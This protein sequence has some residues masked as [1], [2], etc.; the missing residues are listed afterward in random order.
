MSAPILLKF[1]G[2][3]L[4]GPE[5]IVRAVHA[6]Y[7]EVRR[8]RRVIAVTSAFH[9]RT[10]ELERSLAS[11][12]HRAD[13]R[14]IAQVR[15]ALLATGEV[16]TANLLAAALD[17]SG[18]PSQAVDVRRFGPF[19]APGTETPVRF[20]AAGL[21]ALF[22]GGDGAP[23]PAVV[24]LPGFAAVE[25]TPRK[26]PA[27]LGRGGSDM[28]A[29]FVGHACGAEVTLVK[30]VEG[31]YTSDPTRPGPDGASPRRLATVT[32]GDAAGL[33][34]NILQPQAVALAEALDFPFDVVGPGALAGGRGTRVGAD[35]TLAR[36]RP[37]PPP[38]VRVALLGLGNVGS[39][40]FAE[41]SSAPDRF[42][43]TSVLV[44][45]IDGRPR[46]A[47]AAAVLTESFDDVL[48]SSPD[49][50]IET[51][52]GAE[53]ATTW[54]IRALR[55]GVHVV[56][57][58]KVAAATG[59]GA[60]AEAARAGGATFLAGA[61]VGG[62][63]PALERAAAA[64]R[65][66][67]DPLCSIEGVLNGTTNAVL[68]ALEE[69]LSLEQAVARARAAGLAEADPTGDLDGTDVAHKLALLSG[70]AG[71][72]TPRWLGQEGV[73]DADIARRAREALQRGARTKLMG[74][75][76]LT[77]AG[78]LARIAPVDLA[79]GHPLANL[80]GPW[81]GVVLERRSGAR[82]CV[83]G[84]GAGPWPTATAVLGDTYAIARR[85]RRIMGPAPAA[86]DGE[87]A[88]A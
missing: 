88:E 28:T 85:M 36:S 61:A 42:L 62:A 73:D 86:A 22:R 37:T 44:S 67:D 11:F 50:V 55:A 7:A 60:L 1:G 19:V 16:E 74:S 18:V 82:T 58:N 27:L 29:L 47:A 13:A 69:G 49:V 38:P 3:Y 32:F 41:L 54:M 57:A 77:E 10:D 9:G 25:D 24:C 48:A 87:E 6:I 5:D 46:P 43:V 30:D 83:L 63:L 23:G 68:G 59:A 40:V 31:L 78:P 76:H 34:A 33:G 70:A 14:P 2:S 71:W 81:N 75:V 4:R 51:A 45:R 12:D 20:D 52:V 65:D 8:G 35:R 26:A 15:A 79:P 21:E 84:R 17:R 64:S 66:E 53:P 39:R 56:T 72:G 80:E